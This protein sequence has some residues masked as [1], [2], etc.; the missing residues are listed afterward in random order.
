[1]NVNASDPLLAD[2]PPLSLS[3]APALAAALAERFAPGAAAHDRAGTFAVDHVRALQA[4]GWPRLAVPTALGGLGAGL[5]LCVDVHRTLAA[6]DGSTALAVAMHAQTIGAA[7]AGGHWA[8]DAFERLCADVVARGTWVNACASEPDL[9]SPSRGGLPKTAAVR[10]GDGWRIDGRKSFASL[11]PALDAFIVPA[12]IAGADLEEG[13]GRFLVPRGAGVRIEPTWDPLGMRGTGSD[14]LVIERA[15][16]AD[17][18][19]LYRQSAGAPDPNQANANT[20]FTLLSSAVYLGVADGALRF[21]ARFAGERVPTAL[22]RPLAT[23]EGVQRRLGEAELARRTA[24]TVLMTVAR[25]WDEAQ[26]DADARRALGDD[27]VAAKVLVTNQARAVVDACMRVVGGS[28]MGRALPLER[29][30]RD[31]QAGL[32]HPPSDDAAHGLLGRRAL[33]AAGVDPNAGR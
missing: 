18:A 32:F 8:G 13:I 6:G 4:I 2:L 1:M 15:H 14:D 3:A 29:M 28:A 5:A 31:V 22:G 26:A 19:L 23:L 11:A 16:V 30:W 7:A 9:G 27:V 21:A 17:D 20:W 10:D 24:G 12:A 33:I 25:A